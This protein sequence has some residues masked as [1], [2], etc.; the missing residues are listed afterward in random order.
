MVGRGESLYFSSYDTHIGK[1]VDSNDEET[2]VLTT[3]TSIL[4]P[5]R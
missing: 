4:V 1:R 5:G 2:S 3:T